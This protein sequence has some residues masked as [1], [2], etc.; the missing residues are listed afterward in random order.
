MVPRGLPF[1]G[2]PRGS[3]PWSGSGA[4][5]RVYPYPDDRP[6]GPVTAREF[7]PQMPPVPDLSRLIPLSARVVLDVGCGAGEVGAAYRRLNP[8][9]RLLA[10]DR[11]LAMLAAASA[12]Y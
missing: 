7:S 12:H 4:K 9:A 6:L 10:I 11:D 8:N 5:P 3:A 1:G 2:V